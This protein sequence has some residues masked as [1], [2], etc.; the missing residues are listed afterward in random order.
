MPPPRI[1]R[2][3]GVP[4]G[5][6]AEA[7][8]CVTVPPVGACHDTT[9]RHWLHTD[10]YIH[11]VMW[12][13]KPDDPTAPIA[14]SGCALGADQD[15]CGVW[16]RMGLPYVAVV[17]FP[18]QESRWPRQSQDVYAAV[19]KHAAGIVHVSKTVPSNHD[20]AVRMLHARNEWLCA[21]AD[22]LIAV[23][24][25]SKGGTSNCIYQWN[26]FHSY[27]KLHRIDPREISSS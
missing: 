12:Q 17:P 15:A 21:A 13:K 10:M 1:V 7:G 5:E 11:Q 14:I 25:G 23:Y 19:L 16:Y 24:D 26:R 3:A 6:P 27:D 2:S 20:D 4:G 22:E 9:A 8:V 18:G